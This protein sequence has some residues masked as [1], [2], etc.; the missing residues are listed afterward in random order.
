ML[1]RTQ[2]H[3]PKHN[4]SLI[5]TKS[6]GWAKFDFILQI[7][8]QFTMNNNEVLY[9]KYLLMLPVLSIVSLLVYRAD[10]PH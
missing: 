4:H 6:N 5:M 10:P 2:T 9:R 1:N 7:G 3:T 8:L